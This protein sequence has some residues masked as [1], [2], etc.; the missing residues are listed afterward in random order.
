MY[1]IR[2]DFANGHPER[3]SYLLRVGLGLRC[4]DP[5]DK[6][7][8]IMGLIH[9]HEAEKIVVDY[10]APV[11]TV[12]ESAARML[13]EQE[14]SDPFS[15]LALVSFLGSVEAAPSWVPDYAFVTP[16]QGGYTHHSQSHQ[17]HGGSTP[18]V[19][20]SPDDKDVLLVSGYIV[21]TVAKVLNYEDFANDGPTGFQPWYAACAAS[22][23][24]LSYPDGETPAEALWRMLI[25]DTVQLPN[26]QGNG[27]AAIGYGPLYLDSRL[28]DYATGRV[29]LSDDEEIRSEQLRYVRYA[30][31]ITS[32]RYMQS[33]KG[34]VGWTSPHAQEGDVLCVFAGSRCPFL[35]R[36]V[37][38]KDEYRIIGDTYAHGL[39][40]GEAL[41]LP[42]F[43]WIDIHLR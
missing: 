25:A 30:T 41:R 22:M 2:D 23:D 42:E 12:Y 16:I 14:N 17:A 32:S 21:D 27:R 31:G 15:D 9:E 19:R 33:K 4:M 3:L 18:N 40:S 8:A 28:S 1:N 13:Y 38:G 39:M 36:R 24:P 5:R 10:S 35:A 11:G 29:G 7:Y 26:L 43:Q 20:V 34:Y 6:I 37:E